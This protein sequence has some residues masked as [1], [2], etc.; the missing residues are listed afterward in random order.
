MRSIVTTVGSSLLGMSLLSNQAIAESIY[1]P[2]ASSIS[3][4]NT[5]NFE[6]QVTLNRDKG[7]SVVKFYKA[8]GKLPIESLSNFSIPTVLLTFF[9]C[10][11]RSQ[12]KERLGLV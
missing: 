9:S 3:V 5:K 4:F 11:N 7:I 2:S 1:N 10:R 6:K 12:L 8:S